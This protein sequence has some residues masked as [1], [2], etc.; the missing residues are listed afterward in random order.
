MDLL[1]IPFTLIPLHGDEWIQS[2]VTKTFVI[3]FALVSRYA[4]PLYEFALLFL[5]S[6]VYEKREKCYS[7]C[8]AYYN[9]SLTFRM[10]YFS[11]IKALFFL[12]ELL[13]YFI[14]LSLL[15]SWRKKKEK[16]IGAKVQPKRTK[17][18]FYILKQGENYKS[19]R[20]Y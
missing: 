18:R 9:T 14:F 3:G 16:W 5:K 13:H 12:A 8:D 6:I 7:I 2:R 4:I 1:F 19:E 15:S 20:I 17:N 10:R 11:R